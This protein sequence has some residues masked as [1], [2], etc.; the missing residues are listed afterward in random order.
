MIAFLTSSPCIY[1]ALRATLNP[2]NGFVD[3][4]RSCL[5]E[6]P[7]C[8]FVASAPDDIAFTDR[9]AEEMAACFY[10]AG[11]GFSEL[12]RLDRRNQADAR[13]LIW[14]SDFIILSGGHVP[15]QN[16]FFGEI[17]LRELLQNYQGVILGIS[18]G[19]M[20][21]ADRVYIQPEEPGE[22][23][24]EFQRFGE[25]L[26]ITDMNVLPH[27]QTAKDKYLDGRKLYED[28]T[29][30]DSWGE[31]FHV[32]PDGTYLLIKDGRTTLCG[33][34]YRLQDGC[35]EQISQSGDIVILE[36]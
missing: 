14:E 15:T 33:E 24:P 6:N 10:E 11:M 5:P 23:V 13:L 34:A 7:R 16:A 27:Y 12:T 20:N 8:L 26:G 30:A 4:L 25:G 32:F 9:V 17:G 19:T 2:E 21:A 31:C 35:M 29:F 22:S 36:G 28:I 18:A 1:G 3:N